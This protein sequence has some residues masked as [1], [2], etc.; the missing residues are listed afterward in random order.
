VAPVVRPA[1]GCV[2]RWTDDLQAAFR[3]YFSERI[4]AY[5]LFPL[6]LCLRPVTHPPTLR[7]GSESFRLR[8]SG[9]PLFPGDVLYLGIKADQAIGHA[10]ASFAGR[11]VIFYPGAGGL[12]WVGLAGVD[13]E[14][15]VGRHTLKGTVS[16]EGGASQAFAR[17]LRV[18][19][20]GFPVQHI[21]VEEKYVTLASEDSK[22]AE[23][24]NKRLETLW[25]TD[26]SP[27][28][29]HGR[30]LKPVSSSLSS[31]FGRRRIV[32]DKPRSPHSG[33]DLKADTGTPILAANFGRVVLA[34]DLFFSGKTVV[35]DHGLG[36]YT[37]Y[38]HCSKLI[39]NKGD[40]VKKG[41]VIAEVGSTGRVTGPHLH[42]AC[43]ITG[44][45]VDPTKLTD[46]WLSD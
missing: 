19:R 31:G 27:K 12:E 21:R 30:F 37:F 7:E 26:S 10:E 6:L 36:L 13:L 2:R 41:E 35:L 25:Q 24:E 5:C 44:A 29:W 40:A 11:K 22:R 28:L 32:N 9:G 14:T 17:S 45:R 23:E 42:W 20:K 15:K 1:R 46:A 16:F 33:V 4:L 18:A 38:G 39:A 3:N 34:E 8:I 43:R